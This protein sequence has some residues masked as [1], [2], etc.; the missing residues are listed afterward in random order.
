MKPTKAVSQFNGKIENSAEKS[1]ARFTT[2]QFASQ[3]NTLFSELIIRTTT[4]S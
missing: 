1:N 4:F 3:V 2:L